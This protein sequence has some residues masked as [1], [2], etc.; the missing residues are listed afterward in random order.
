M[1]NLQKEMV[2]G[3]IFHTGP[4][5]FLGNSVSIKATLEGTVTQQI[6]IIFPESTTLSTNR[7][8]DLVGGD[9][10][11]F[12]PES[13]FA[14]ARLDRMEF[15]FRGGS[16]V[17]FTRIVYQ[18]GIWTPFPGQ[19]A[20][21]YETEIAAG[22]MNPGTKQKSVEIKLRGSLMIPESVTN[23][24]GLGK[25]GWDVTGYINMETKYFYMAAAF[26]TEIPL[27][28]EKL[29]VF[30]KSKIMLYFVGPKAHLAI[31]GQL[32]LRPKGQDPILLDGEVSFAL[33]KSEIFGQGYMT[34]YWKNPFGISDQLY[35]H[36]PGAGFGAD[37]KTTPFPAPIFA[38]QG[39][40]SV[41]N[42]Q[43]D[44]AQFYGDATL[45]M[46]STDPT[47][48]MIDAEITRANLYDIIGAFFSEGTPTELIETTKKTYLRNARLRI[49]PPGPGIRIFGEYYEPGIHIQGIY[50]VGDYTGSMLISIDQYQV[51]VYAGMSPLK[52]DGISITASSDPSKGPEAFIQINKSN[53]KIPLKGFMAIDGKVDA[54]GLS[55]QADI[56]MSDAGFNI[57]VDG[58]IFDTFQASLDMAGTDLL[59]QG[60]VY[61]KAE[62][63][64][65]GDLAKKIAEAASAEIE[66]V[67]QEAHD[68]F[69]NDKANLEALRPQLNAKKNQLT[70]KQEE[71]RADY[72]RLCGL[73]DQRAENERAKTAK[74]AEIDA[75]QSQITALD[76]KIKNEAYGS[77][78]FIKSTACPP[79]YSF[80]T[81]VIKKSGCYK[82]PTNYTKAGL[83]DIGSDI[84]CWIPE[85]SDF[86]S[87]VDKGAIPFLGSCSS[88]QFT[89]GVM[90]RC[91][92]CPPGYTRSASP[93]LESAC[94]KITK[95]QYKEAIGPA[96]T[97]CTG[98]SFKDPRN[99]GECWECDEGYERP[100]L[101][102]NPVTSDKACELPN[103]IELNA[104]LAGLIAEKE[105]M[106]A[107]LNIIINGIAKA[108]A[109]LS[110]VT[111]D[112]CNAVNNTDLINQDPRVLPIFT[113]WGALSLQVNELQSVVDVAQGLTDNSLMATQWLVENAGKGMNIVQITKAEFEGCLSM[114]SDGTVAMK[115]EG[116][117][118][119]EAVSGSFEMNFNTPEEGIKNLANALLETNF[120]ITSASNG[121]CTRPKVARPD[122]DATAISDFKNKVKKNPN[123]KE[124]ERLKKMEK[125]EWAG[126]A[127][128]PDDSQEK[129]RS[130]PKP[131]KNKVMINAVILE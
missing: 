23:Y 76:Y 17:K 18:S 124:K 28:P 69:E 106:V 39:G 4:A 93:I 100:L 68:N 128:W 60:S 43:K 54:L 6:N 46:H 113:E 73:M 131:K 53:E 114:I 123:I 14:A 35:I 58:K 50:D 72:R 3:K 70:A 1:G 48:N 11:E 40:F 67:A 12:I 84:A 56:Y 21:V 42:H 41:G 122:I 85:S 30:K 24:M 89:M 59:K 86:K 77:A 38:L 57:E 37:F 109:E 105:L 83:N 65:E 110:S 108:G 36:N 51:A 104:Q 2:D 81:S 63:E 13:L 34:G 47:Q 97:D 88:G 33:N 126:D 92:E 121:T 95:A 101:S 22:I 120:P 9:L 64:S 7:L 82:C 129:E 66:K 20:K 116:K 107:D 10:R 25:T 125:P 78:N 79:G 94:V 75:K 52:Y 96:D 71:V 112:V 91:Y 32:E 90:G 5:T 119:D 118:A 29:I 8:V 45:V 61:V 130:Q 55:T 103:L 80:Y 16:Y 117:L 62:F 44:K 27:H 102:V 98:R 87:G 31:G 115:F 99:G 74:Q 26:N 19:D 15:E 127:Q 49:V 111:M